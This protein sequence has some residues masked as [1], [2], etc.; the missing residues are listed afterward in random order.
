MKPT[1]IN[2]SNSEQTN[3]NKEQH[4]PDNSSNA[5]NSGNDSRR[6]PQFRVRRKF[7]F[8]CVQVFN[9]HL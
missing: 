3:P 4:I 5:S 6:F 2:N 7:K 1:V 8:K 9:F